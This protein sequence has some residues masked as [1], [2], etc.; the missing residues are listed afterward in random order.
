MI[1][2]VSGCV[3]SQPQYDGPALPKVEDA[4]EE[5]RN[6]DVSR[7]GDDSRVSAG[8]QGHG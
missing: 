1:V 3:V 4:C 5:V 8:G 2:I 7:R 6:G